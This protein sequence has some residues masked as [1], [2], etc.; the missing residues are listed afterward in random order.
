[1][2]TNPRHFPC[3]TITRS[4]FCSGTLCIIC[5]SD[6]SM[7]SHQVGAGVFIEGQHTRRPPT[8]LAI[9]MGTQM[10]V[11]DAELH[12]V[13]QAAEKC[14]Q[15]LARQQDK[16]AWIFTDN[17]A[18]AQRIASLTA[19]PAQEV[20]LQLADI[21]D[22]LHER[23]NFLHIQ[24]VPG[25]VDVEGNERADKLAKEATQKTPLPRVKTSLSYL[26]RVVKAK[27]DTE[28]REVWTAMPNKGRNYTGTFRSKPDAIFL[29]NKRQLVATVTQIRTNVG[30]FRSYL[31]D[32]PNSDIDHPFCSCPRRVHQT[33][34]H[35]LTKCPLYS[36]ERATMCRESKCP[37]GRAW[38]Q[39]VLHTSYGAP[40]LTN[41]LESTGIL[42]RRWILGRDRDEDDGQAGDEGGRAEDGEADEHASGDEA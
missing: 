31:A 12:G 14:R 5:Y 32:L 15:F 30:Y 21:A 38:I 4:N 19:A 8:E 24:W 27:R 17:Q 35:L 40:A 10:E 33:V 20:A 41:F 9:P 23:N 22:T 13:L 37:P 2:M 1:M 11:Y 29:T 36:K 28:W 39:T 3:T 6:G 16:K 26:R 7:L 34:R 42:T 25:D 18:A